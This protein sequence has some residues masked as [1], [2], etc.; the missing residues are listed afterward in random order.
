MKSLVEEASSITKAIEK[1]WIRAGKPQSFSVKIFEIPEVGFLGFTKKSAKVGIFFEEPVPERTKKHYS[2]PANK[3][4]TKKPAE[5][6]TRSHAPRREERTETRE[7]RPTN[8]RRPNNRPRNN[9]RR[10]QPETQQSQPRNNECSQAPR[11]PRPQ[12]RPV[13]RTSSQ[14]RTPTQRPARRPESEPVVSKPIYKPV[15]P[16]VKTQKP[17]EPQEPAAPQATRRPPKF[18]GRRFSAPKKNKSE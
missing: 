15:A 12:T 10:E 14:E 9:D 1:A 13:E 11:S 8:D 16:V 7:S 4:Y 18:S 5:Q 3:W 17:T 6:N 2:R